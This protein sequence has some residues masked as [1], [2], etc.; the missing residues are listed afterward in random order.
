MLRLRGSAAGALNF[1]GLD[2]NTESEGYPN[3]EA[4][5]L[6]LQ[7]DVPPPQPAPSAGANGGS[8]GAGGGN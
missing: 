3:L 2:L 7:G 6:Y 8:G 4:S 1:D 5:Q